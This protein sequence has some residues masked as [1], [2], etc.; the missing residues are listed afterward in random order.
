MYLWYEKWFSREKEQ[1]FIKKVEEKRGE[2]MPLSSD[3]LALEA[4]HRL[5]FSHV[6]EH[7]HGRLH[8]WP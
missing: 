5:Q 7:A 6:S 8:Q 3:L 1:P 2:V 4:F